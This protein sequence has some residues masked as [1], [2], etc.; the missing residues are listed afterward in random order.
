MDWGD[1]EHRLRLYCAKGGKTSRRRQADRVRQLLA[2][3][4][5]QGIRR[6]DQIGRRHILEWYES[7]PSAAPST[8]RDRY[9][10]AALLWQLLERAGDPPKPKIQTA[11]PIA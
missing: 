6:P 7:L 9:Y 2:F 4:R 5:Q 8:L 10:A 3:A 11:K 1:L